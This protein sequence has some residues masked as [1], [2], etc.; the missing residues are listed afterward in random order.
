VSASGTE[1]A[2]AALAMTRASV[3][4]LKGETSHGSTLD[5]LMLEMSAQDDGNQMMKVI[6]SLAGLAAM[7]II[8][9]AQQT[10]R[11]E[12]ELLDGLAAGMR[13]DEEERQ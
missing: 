5:T 7:S 6:F 4:S 9:L 12:E 3:S 1:A 11:S 10:G 8:V 2:Q 13:G